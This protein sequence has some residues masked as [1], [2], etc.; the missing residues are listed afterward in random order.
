M[1]M[2]GAFT[3]AQ[4]KPATGRERM[5]AAL[6][7]GPVDRPPVWF[8]RQAG[9]HLPGYRAIRERMS[10]LELCRDEVANAE[11]SAEPVRRY[12]IDAAIVFNDILIPLRDMGMAMDFAPGPRFQWLVGSEA[13]VSALKVPRYGPGT[14]VC[15]CLR[16]LRATLG[17]D[18]A[19]LGFVGAPFTVA[20][21]AICGSGGQRVA[22][23]AG[24]VAARRTLFE[25]MQERLLPILVEYAKAQVAAGADVIQIFESLA[26]ELDP[27]V[28]R[29]VGLPG[30]LGLIEVIRG[31][32]PET[33]VIAFGRGIWGVIPEI[34]QSGAGAISLDST[35]P[36][37][38]ARTVLRAAGSRAALQGNLAPESLLGSPARAGQDATALLSHWREI[39]PLPERGAEVGPT[40][41][42]FNLG[43]G[44]P[45][46]AKP[47]AVQAVVDAVGA[48]RFDSPARPPGLGAEKQS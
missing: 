46:G 20:A 39:V 26:Y 25:S 31:A 41:W 21:F 13:D 10:F 11:V 40:G 3:V 29:E 28:Y 38:A 30:L 19:I 14:D 2:S 42:V 36:L 32:V 22:P 48:F 8:M 37:G 27:G 6:S 16:A 43:H 23:L 1:M 18:K 44:V 5:L 45:E 15:R 33:P 12:G 4:R 7:L 17:A 9:R 24:D 35:R 34:A 47:E